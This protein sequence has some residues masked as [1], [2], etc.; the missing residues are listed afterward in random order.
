MGT[1]GAIEIIVSWEALAAFG[2]VVSTAGG[3]LW[4]V[5]RT[6]SQHM[7]DNER[8]LTGEA[9]VP[10]SVCQVTKEAIK[11]ELAE[12]RKYI[13]DVEG[14]S[15]AAI[16]ELKKDICDKIDDLGDSIRAGKR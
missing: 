11:E 10:A 4:G 5:W 8:H 15:T 12:T 3:V 7:G 14:R 2:A 16:K 13:G 6:L 1:V 9:Y